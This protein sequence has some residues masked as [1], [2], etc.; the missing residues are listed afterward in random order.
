MGVDSLQLEFT[1][2]R[3]CCQEIRLVLVH[4]AFIHVNETDD[5]MV[6]AFSASVDRSVSRLRSVGFY[7]K[8]LTILSNQNR[9]DATVVVLVVV[10]GPPLCGTAE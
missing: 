9:Y 7:V 3:P 6:L 5:V 1:T 10:G 4:T 8:E 2:T